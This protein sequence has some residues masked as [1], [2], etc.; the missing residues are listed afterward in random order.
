[1]KD[2]IVNGKNGL[3]CAYCGKT[4]DQVM[5]V[6]GAMSQKCADKK[7][8]WCMVY[9]TGKMSCPDCYA[10]ASKDGQSAAD[11]FVAKINKGAAA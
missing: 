2:K 7:Q 9:G 10:V 6:I 11:K 8:D 1:M 5:F 3:V 4:K